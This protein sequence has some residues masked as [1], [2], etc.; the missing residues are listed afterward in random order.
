MEYSTAIKN[1]EE[2]YVITW[3]DYQVIVIKWHMEHG[4]IFYQVHI[5][6]T[7]ENF[8]KMDTH[9]INKL[10]KNIDRYL[11]CICTYTLSHT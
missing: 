3:K 1:H 8:L 7:Y 4:S 6:H 2:Q 11:I 5:L 10:F 9:R